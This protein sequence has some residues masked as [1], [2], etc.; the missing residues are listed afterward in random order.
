LIYQ[1]VLD[2][3]FFQTKSKRITRVSKEKNSGQTNIILE[4]S[5][6]MAKQCLLLPLL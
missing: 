4:F 1:E 2:Y 3:K 5:R 6:V